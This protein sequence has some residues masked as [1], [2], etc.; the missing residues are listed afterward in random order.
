VIGFALVMGLFP[1]FKVNGLLRRSL[2]EQQRQKDHLAQFLQVIEQS[3]ISIIITDL[4]GKIEYANPYFL[5]LTGYHTKEVLHQNP[6]ILKSGKLS[7][8]T[9]EALWGSLKRGEVW[10]GELINRRKDGSEYIEKGF[11]APLR[12]HNG[13]ISRFVAIKED[14][15]AQKNAQDQIYHL[16]FYDQ[17]THLPNRQKML[18]DIIENPPLACAILDIDSF[19]EIN[20]L[21]GIE[22]GDDILRQMGTWLAQMGF[23]VY[24]TGGN[25]FTTLF[26]DSY[27]T[28]PLLKERLERLMQALELHLFHIKEESISLRM[29]VGGAMGGLELLTHADIALH[30]A[31]SKKF[32][33]SFYEESGNV[34]ERYRHNLLM[35]AQIRE[36]LIEGRIVCY[37]QPIADFKTGKVYKYETL[38]R[39]IDEDGRV[40]APMEFL[41]IAKKM[42]LYPRITQAVVAQAC[43]LFEH[44]EEEFSINL[45]TADMED[46]QAMQMIIEVIQKTH[47][48]SRIVFEILESEG[49]ENYETIG[50]FI[51]KVKS[52]GA[53]IAIDDFGTGYSNFEH[54]LKLNVDYIKIDGS[55][56]KNIVSHTRNQI[57]AQTIVTF[58]QK[59]GAQ[60]I[61][62]YVSD[63]AI[64]NYVS[65]LGVDYAQGYYIGKPEPL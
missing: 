50:V 55:L 39:M 28:K 32:P 51:A 40:I 56:I 62:E 25:E 20:D 29:S 41:P 2:K 59:I 30:V 63:E 42:K 60:T 38:V 43:A 46:R 8:S 11:I 15:T 18:Q 35:A 31:K 4:E 19:K 12:S 65:T 37:Y 54:I 48:A 64:F 9:Y 7:T 26:Y 45:S 57:V 23:T 17:L 5:K 44:K 34:K 33:I 49:I 36:A 52:L 14:I 6:R 3:P 10:Q 58:A 24:R 53:K 21:F 16:A 27:A 1:F 13:S 61:A 47:T 22:S